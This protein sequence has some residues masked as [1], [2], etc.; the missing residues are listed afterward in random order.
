MPPKK[1]KKIKRK[2]KLDYSK[3]DNA[4]IIKMIN[5][6]QNEELL[7]RLETMNSMALEDEL[8]TILYPHLDDPDFNSKL[9][10]KKEFNDLQSEQVLYDIE[11]QSNILCGEKKHFEL[12]PHQQFVKSFLSSQTPYNGLFLYH[13]LGTGKTCSGISIAEEMRDY[14]KQM[15]VT[16]RIII[17]ASPNV[18]ENFKLQLFDK[19]GLTNINGIWNLKSCT[20]NKFLKEINPMNMKGLTKENVERLVKRIITRNYL[21]MGP[22]QFSNYINRTITTLDEDGTTRV[23]LPNKKQI[24]AIQKEFSNRLV[25]IDEIHNIKTVRDIPEKKTTQNLLKLVTHALNLKLL[26]LSATPMF[27]SP[28]EII[29]L[30]NLMNKNDNRT[31]LKPSDVFDATGNLLV[32]GGINIGKE[33]LIKKSRGYISYVRGDNPYMY[34]FRIYPKMFSKTNTMESY[35]P[36]RLQLNGIPI[37]QAIE[38]L[39]LYVLPLNKYQSDVYLHII[40]ENID[41]IQKSKTGL[42]YHILGSPLQALNIVYPSPSFDSGTQ[43]PYDTLIGKKGLKRIVQF[44]KNKTNFKYKTAI[45]EKYGR[46]FDSE[47]IGNYSHKINNIIK[48]LDN[49]EGIVLIYSQYIDGGCVP[50]ALALEEAGFSRA[51]RDNLFSEKSKKP[52]AG[53][54][55]MITGD[56]NLSPN[57]LNEIKLATGEDNTNGEK[58]KVIIISEAG[59][60]GIDLKNIR[61]IHIM[62][63]WYNLNRQE[64]IIGR[65]VRTCSHKLLPFEKRNA[66]IFLYGTELNDATVESADMYVYRLAERKA[67]KMGLITRILKENATDCILNKNVLTEEMFGTEKDIELGNKQIIKYKVGDKPFSSVCDYMST[68]QYECIPEKLKADATSYTYNEYFINLNIDS[69]ILKIKDIFSLAYIYE[70]IDIIKEV[71][72]T[73]VYSLVQ[74]N[75][76]LEKM[77]TDNSIILF[78]VLNRPGNLINV[79]K[80]YIFQPLSIDNKHISMY[81]RVNPIEYKNEKIRIILPDKIGKTENSGENIFKKL[82]HKFKYRNLIT[83]I[84]KGIEEI[85]WYKA[86][87]NALNLPKGEADVL[88]DET[89]NKRF[90]HYFRDVTDEFKVSFFISHMIDVISLDDKKNLFEYLL[91]E[92]EKDEYNEETELFRQKLFEK[93][94][95]MTI[96]A[97]GKIFITFASYEDNNIEILE[98]IDKK[99]QPAKPVDIK[100]ITKS[101]KSSYKKIKYSS[102][103][104]FMTPFKKKYSVFKIKNTT[105]K[106]DTGY[107]CDQKGKIDILRV[108]NE[109]L[110]EGSNEAKDVFTYENTIAIENARELCVD[111]ELMFRYFNLIKQND[112]TWFLSL[113]DYLFTKLI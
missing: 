6:V 43:V 88:H 65:G 85:D 36:P 48:S 55:S 58:I 34:P 96:E 24:Q 18:Q 14:M 92:I 16:K 32:R 1:G 2:I 38:F 17:V 26:L 66:Q 84:P 23:L 83:F 90:I 27:N 37:I 101:L 68:C 75:A 11:E 98:I 40:N 100:K 67:V 79:G 112:V 12:M 99:L 61:Q 49:S 89:T 57:N 21:F 93:F 51:G 52:F 86:A 63:P 54:Y 71:N 10:L 59:S 39:D 104:G 56:I 102:Y 28:E 109:T 35:T 5:R 29:W 87:G 44:T 97:F 7:K 62:E 76:A 19:R 53:Y 111:Q 4:S 60:E 74:I 64:Q 33:R 108:L 30:L 77:V 81:D 31:G 50:I 78:D 3:H 73:N 45:L 82:K 25:I 46:I 113:E 9:N 103:I 107:R 91:E 15:G 41:L 8:D 95:S 13:G 106:R 20:G 22:E 69:I 80:F 110:K 94:H 72:H 105:K 70:K 42:G 47:L